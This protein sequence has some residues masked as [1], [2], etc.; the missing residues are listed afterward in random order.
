M[1]IPS[2]AQRFKDCW[3][4]EMPR[5]TGPSGSESYSG[6]VIG[7]E[8]NRDIGHDVESLSDGLFRMKV[9][10]DY[11][12]YWIERNDE[13]EI[14]AGLS[15]FEKGMMVK[16][17]GKRPGA[18]IY[19]SKF[20]EMIV[21]SMGGSLLFSGDQIS[22]EGFGIW[23]NLITK[24]SHKLFGYDPSDPK[25]FTD[26]NSVQDLDKFSGPEDRYEDLRFV[27]SENAKIRCGE[28]WNHFHSFR[29][30]NLVHG[31]Y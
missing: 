11:T 19:A 4:F 9:A 17:V 24:G 3:L 12:Y 26:I 8:A 13:I 18:A 25:R 5:R 29:I 30:H 28:I 31:V 2:T 15:P 1:K 27:L 16:H 23:V 21:D 7:L 6:L 10:S 14:V 20:Y 22:D